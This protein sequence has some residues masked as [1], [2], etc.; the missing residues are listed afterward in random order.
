MISSSQLNPRIYLETTFEIID[1][2]LSGLAEK[3]LYNLSYTPNKQT[4]L[5]DMR[6]LPI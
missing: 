6:K 4:M 3:K 5:L 1:C 2:T